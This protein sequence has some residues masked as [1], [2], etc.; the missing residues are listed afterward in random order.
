MWFGVCLRWRQ[1]RTIK[2]VDRLR[3]LAVDRTPRQV[4]VAAVQVIA[5]VV[6]VFGVVALVQPL[7]LALPVLQVAQLALNLLFDGD[8]AFPN[9]PA[10]CVTLDGRTLEFG[11]CE[12]LNTPIVELN[13]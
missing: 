12:R 4:G 11:A 7:Q 5:A 10:L 9:G 6:I 3:Q 2:C 1:T 8:E 13:R